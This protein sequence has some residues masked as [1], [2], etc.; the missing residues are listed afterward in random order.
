MLKKK[1]VVVVVGKQEVEIPH[2]LR[3]LCVPIDSVKLWK[4]N[5]RKNDGAAKKLAELIV[6]NG[7]RVPIVVDQAGIIRAGNTRFKAAKLL[8]MASIPVIRQTFI[9]EVAATA[10]A[11]SDN[12]ASEFSQWDDDVLE[13]LMKT[14]GITFEETGF[15][16]QDFDMLT[17]RLAY[18]KERELDILP[19]EHK[20]PKC[21]FEY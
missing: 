16:K 20:C 17:K 1:A 18:N 10:F 6:R 2:D 13:R 19:T 5:P 9:S 15:D 8:G 11:L 3:K 7:F 4:D 14:E 21:G 12:K